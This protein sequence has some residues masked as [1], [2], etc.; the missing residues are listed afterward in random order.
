MYGAEEKAK[1]IKTYLENNCNAGKTVREL[2]YPT[3]PCMIKWA[4]ACEETAKKRPKRIHRIY[5]EEEKQHAVELYFENDC[6]IKKT[7]RELGYGSATG[8]Q[9]FLAGLE[10]LLWIK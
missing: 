8:Q 1:A 4:K 5:T 7:V 3:V 10:K 9:D 2:G 6:N